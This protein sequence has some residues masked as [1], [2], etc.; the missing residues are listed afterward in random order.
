[1]LQ[2]Y[3]K[4]D[5]VNC[6]KGITGFRKSMILEMWDMT[7]KLMLLKSMYDALSNDI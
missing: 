1:M 7:I 2:L 5:S 6:C 3:Y 4:N